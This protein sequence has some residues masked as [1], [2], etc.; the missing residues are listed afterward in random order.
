MNLQTILFGA[1]IVC[2]ACAQ[3]QNQPPS[4][5]WKTSVGIAARVGPRSI[6]SD[7]DRVL[8]IPN[9]DVKY[10]DWFFLNPIEG[11]GLRT[12]GNGLTLS[13]SVAIDLNNRN[14]KN[15]PVLQGFAKV[16]IAPALRLK[17]QYDVGPV[18]LSAVSSTRIADGDANGTTL[19]LEASYR[20]YASRQVIASFGANARFM[21]ENFAQNFVSVSASDS[22]A[23]GKAQYRAKSGLLDTGL[24]AQG[25]FI[26]NREWAIVSR[27]QIS[28]LSSNASSSPAVEKKNQTSVLI[29]TSY[30]F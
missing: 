15:N 17:A 28:Q 18:G 4:Q 2:C 10:Q 16:G 9:F 5:D 3:A 20:A 29:A 21:D 27:I 23:S 22:A 24:F 8:V 19:T 1:G 11:V 14:A 7:H 13:G 6:G 30:S 26:L 12:S 25:V